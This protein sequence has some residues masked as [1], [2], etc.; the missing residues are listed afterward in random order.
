MDG[1]EIFSYYSAAYISI[2]NMINHHKISR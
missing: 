2:T 1:Q